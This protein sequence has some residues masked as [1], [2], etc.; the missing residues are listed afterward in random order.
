MKALVE[1]AN[2]AV[3]PVKHVWEGKLNT[4]CA[5]LPRDETYSLGMSGYALVLYGQL[6][7]TGLASLTTEQLEA[8]AAHARAY[9]KTVKAWLHASRENAS[10]KQTQYVQSNVFGLLKKEVDAIEAEIARRS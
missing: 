9:R 8:R 7:P 5:S 10:A 4:I 6:T 2:V 1:R 3:W